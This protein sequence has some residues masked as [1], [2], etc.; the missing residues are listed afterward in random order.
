MGVHIAVGV[1]TWKSSS[2]FHYVSASQ[3]EEAI[4]SFVVPIAWEQSYRP[5]APET[6]YE[7]LGSSSQ[8][9]MLGFSY[10]NHF[11]P[12]STDL[13]PSLLHGSLG[14]HT[15]EPSI[16]H[17]EDPRMFS[18]ST[19]KA[20]TVSFEEQIFSTFN[21]VEA[22]FAPEEI[23]LPISSLKDW[24]RSV[25]AKSMVQPK[26]LTLDECL[27]GLPHIPGSTA[28][29][30]NS[31]SGY[32]YI[33]QGL[34]KDKLFI[35]KEKLEI[36]EPSL[37]RKHYKL[38]EQLKQG[39]VP[40]VPFIMTLKDEKLKLKKVYDEQKTRLFAC[41]SVD[42][43]LLCRRYFFTT[44]LSLYHLPISQTFM[45][46][47]M[48]RLSSDWRA[49]CERMLEVGDMG[50]DADFTNFDRTLQMSLVRGAVDILLT[51]IEHELTPLE[52]ET[53]ITFL[54]N[55]TF[56]HRNAVF[57]TY[58]GN[59]SGCLLTMVINCLVN[60]VLHRAAW[61]HIM[62]ERAPH[63]ASIASYNKFTR[64]VRGGDDTATTVSLQ[65]RE[66]YNGITVSQYLVSRGMKVTSVDKTDNI[67][68]YKPFRDLVFLKNQTTVGPISNFDPL[69]DW[70]S[71]IEIA[72][73]VRINKNNP[74]MLLAT[75]ENANV[76]LRSVFFW[77]REKFEYVRNTF[78]QR[79]PQ[80]ELFRFEELL[81]IYSHHG[82]FVGSHPDYATK[83][84]YGIA[85]IPSIRNR[86]NG[87]ER[88]SNTNM[89]NQTIN[90]TRHLKATRQTGALDAEKRMPADEKMTGSVD[91]PTVM[92]E[93]ISDIMTS[94]D[95]QSKSTDN[96]HGT[97]IQDTAQLT[98]A[99]FSIGKVPVNPKNDRAVAYMND[100]DWDL[101]KIEE[102]YTLIDTTTWSTS[103]T[104][105]TVLLEKKLPA[106][107]LVTS[108]Q[109]IP[110]D[111]MTYWKCS[112]IR[113]FVVVK[114]SPF[115]QGGL[116]CGYSPLV[117]STFDQKRLINMGASLLN[118][119]RDES[120]TVNIPYRYIVGMLEADKDVMGT[121]SISVFSP[122]KTGSTNVQ[123]VEI[124]L[125]ADIID[126]HFK[127]PEVIPTPSYTQ[128]KRLTVKK[129]SGNTEI[130]NGDTHS[131]N[132]PLKEESLTKMCAG[133]GYVQR[134]PVG[135]FQD[136]DQ[137][138]VQ[139]FK[140][141]RVLG[142][143]SNDIKPKTGI[144]YSTTMDALHRL[145][146]DFLAQTYMAYRGS[147]VFKI[148]LLAHNTQGLINS[149]AI[150]GYVRYYAFEPAW[151]TPNNSQS[152]LVGRTVFDESDPAEFMVPYC[153]NTFV[154]M[155][156][157]ENYEKFMIP[158]RLDIH[159]ENA[160]IHETNP[161]IEVSVA[162]ADDYHVGF[163]K[164][165]GGIQLLD[166]WQPYV[167]PYEMQFTEPIGRKIQVK[168]Q[169][170]VLD[171]IDRALET[172]LPIAEKV[173]RL[174]A[175]LDAHPI[176][177]PPTPLRPKKTGPEGPTDIVQYV[178]RLLTTNHNGMNLPDEGAFGVSS[179]ETNIMNLY[180]NTKSWV[181]SLN[182]KTSDTV[183][184][185]LGSFYA[186]PRPITSG[187]ANNLH[188]S[189][190][191]LWNFWT[192]STIYQFEVFA[193]GMHRGQLLCVYQIRETDGGEA[194]P[195]IAD[196]TQTYFTTIDISQTKGTISIMLPY[197]SPVPYQSLNYKTQNDRTPKTVG[198]L[199]VYVQ[200][201][202]RCTDAVAN[203]VDVYVFK[204]FGGDF[205]SRVFGNEAAANRQSG[206]ALSTEDAWH[207]VS[208][209]INM[210]DSLDPEE[211]ERLV[212]ISREEKRRAR[213]TPQVAPN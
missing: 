180:T 159:V 42:H 103:A 92:P 193:S 23:A 209:P 13:R 78:L 82:Y 149:S 87:A 30:I 71:I 73:W 1:D 199:H 211:F 124:S 66:L 135:H 31:S 54:A 8:L 11:Q 26:L 68:P 190:P 106:D 75:Q 72:Y 188:D 39:T 15:T 125:Y 59:A 44:M 41:G 142:L 70:R 138:L 29:D 118:V 173:S 169:S 46:I 90:T 130:K 189:L 178:D 163:F 175:L 137:D 150:R 102:K 64:H 143:L 134:L 105:G 121:F 144:I 187:G 84:D 160:T 191:E 196:A 184:K 208:E 213:L 50:F 152:L 115:Y 47:G 69:P 97:T 48:D 108:A 55:P 7:E 201:T 140:R 167:H 10:Y 120:A 141:Y 25:C 154:A 104:Q 127:V 76:T 170:G 147:L 117:H 83:H 80:L 37:E 206:S 3:L 109:K 176:T 94:T 85:R 95:Q 52:R 128:Y 151:N 22:K 53:L 166:K 18:K 38:I 204:R 153:A 67:V 33:S 186:G 81:T 116:L 133:L 158:G 21:S 5:T 129:Q 200:N 56:I 145:A 110:F 34:G 132:D 28:M 20:H 146:Q 107:I 174:G 210:G 77:G 212:R 60:E 172:T 36:I 198:T 101:T 43:F 62:T 49:L 136:Q 24:I 139:L 161:I 98:T 58:G 195:A 112:H 197:L 156:Q 63:L 12:T 111:V 99:N 185:L 74:S 155:L 192:G 119:A 177:Y 171:F 179:P 88:Q 14:P 19:S 205:Q 122:L 16:L 6:Y 93:K 181:S 203:N 148:R 79:E 114:A 86:E 207:A 123:N 27:N 17:P 40:F 162:L 2:I 113:M 96:I 165:F 131:I 35:R 183:G 4:Q 45:P 202:L 91:D 168:K 65:V 61:M 51:P 164:G 157:Q 194:A 89:N 57:R 126:N 182:W 100:I 32:P 9:E